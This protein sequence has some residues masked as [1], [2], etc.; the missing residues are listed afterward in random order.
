MITLKDWHDASA[1]G[2]KW[3]ITLYSGQCH[4]DKH[5]QDR[6]LDSISVVSRFFVE[7][8]KVA[9]KRTHFSA[10]AIVEV[11]RYYSAIEDNDK[12]FKINNNITTPLA[13]ISMAMFP[14]LNNFFETRSHTF[15]MENVG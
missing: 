1:D 11:L 9:E 6:L 3:Y 10:K 8:H 15:K 5:E 2:K 7:S 13:K 12:A 14:A 4:L